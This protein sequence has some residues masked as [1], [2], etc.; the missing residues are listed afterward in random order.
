MFASRLDSPKRKMVKFLTKQFVSQFGLGK[1]S[2]TMDLA[3]RFDEVAFRRCSLGLPSLPVNPGRGAL[4][5][6]HKSQGC[7]QLSPGES[8]RGLNRLLAF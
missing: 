8:H 7:G 2:K 1:E 5:C 6:P 3:E 4:I